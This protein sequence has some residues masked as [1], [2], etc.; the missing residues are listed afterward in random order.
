MGGGGGGSWV[1][2][3]VVLFVALLPALR[4]SGVEY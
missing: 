3:D 4:G 2:A 1:V